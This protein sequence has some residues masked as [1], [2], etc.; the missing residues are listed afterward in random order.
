M[1]RLHEVALKA[2]TAAQF[3]LIELDEKVLIKYLLKFLLLLNTYMH[4]NKYKNTFKKLNIF[5]S[6]VIFIK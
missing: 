1:M 6:S 5:I 3:P 2:D 4:I